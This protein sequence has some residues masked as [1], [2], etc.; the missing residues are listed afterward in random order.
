MT[1]LVDHHLEGQ[2]ALLWG[3]LSSEGW[4]FELPLEVVTLSQVGLP[5]DSNDRLVWQFAQDHQMLLL[6]GNRRMRGE[7]SLEQIIREGTTSSS[8]PVV[9]I[10]NVSRM[11]ESAYRQLCAVRLIE[12]ILDVDKYLGT[13][14]LYIP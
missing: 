11:D 3:T 9:T 13:G 5:V 2:A 7:D 14:R 12:I 4:L 10:G 8:F 6:T 1:I